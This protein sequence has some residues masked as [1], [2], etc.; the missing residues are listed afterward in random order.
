MMVIYNIIALLLTPLLAL[1][2]PI[3]LL[4][5]PEKRKVI[6]KRLGFGL[7]LPARRKK[8]TLWIHALSVGEVTSAHHLVQQ[9]H[10]HH[11]ESTTVIF[12][13]T[14]RSGQQP[15]KRLIGPYC[16]AVIYYPFDFLPVIKYFHRKIQ[17]DLF[18]LIETDFW[19]NMLNS[20][21]GSGVPLL[22]F[23][24]RISERS[25]R[26]YRR[27]SFF[28]AP[29]FDKFTMLCMQT[30]TDVNNMVRLGIAES[31]AVTLGNLMVGSCGKAEPESSRLDRIFPSHSIIVCAGST[32]EGEERAILDAFLST[33]KTTGEPLHLILA[34]RKIS[35]CVDLTE[36][37]KKHRLSASLFSTA[38]A[39]RAD[40]TIVDTLGDLATLYRYADVSYIGGSLVDE[41]GHNPLEA[42]RYGCPV[43]FGPHMDDFSEISRE[44]QQC[45]AALMVEDSASLRDT[46]ERLITDANLRKEMGERALHY[47]IGHTHVIADHLQLIDRYL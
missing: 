28:F 1:A 25:M 3:Y 18:I 13:T 8:N 12:S 43:L 37:V 4:V 27:V 36:L 46:L 44:L 35:R 34:P 15:A 31:T 2:L 23:N 10:L 38:E 41:G 11:Q 5:H 16:D 19:P 45:G 29:L 6:S 39:D 26:Q 22:L 32:H 14:T 33:K 9:F 42:T 17:P 47:S 40:V 21:A 24:G 20:L 7:E 30:N